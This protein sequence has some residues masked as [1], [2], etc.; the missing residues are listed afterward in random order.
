MLRFP[1]VKSSILGVVSVFSLARI[2]K[3][4]K[5]EE[6]KNIFALYLSP[7]SR[8]SL[9]KYIREKLGKPNASVSPFIVIKSNATSQDQ[10]I[11]E[12]LYGERAVFRLK[13]IITSEK[14]STGV[15]KISSMIGEISDDKFV[16]SLPLE[17]QY[18]PNNS[19]LM[20]LPTLLANTGFVRPQQTFW[21]GRLP[22]SSLS[23]RSYPAD[24][25]TQSLIPFEKQIVV[26]GRLCSSEYV[27]ED[28]NCTFDRRQIVTAPV[29]EKEGEKA[30]ESETPATITTK[31]QS[32]TK[33]DESECPVCKFMK[34][35]IPT[36]LTIYYFLLATHIS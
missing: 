8:E 14:G 1:L 13:G 27:D 19:Y 4:D 18:D 31:D 34:A 35:G 24:K 33:E 21:K 17:G 23:G 11:Y 32:K 36:I 5:K 10:Y 3:L 7:S 9:N 15:G 25:V 29:V 22:P 6:S 20:D 28:G 30:P 2:T 26:S 12:P 16:P